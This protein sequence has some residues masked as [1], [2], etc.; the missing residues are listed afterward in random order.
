MSLIPVNVEIRIWMCC[1][2][3]DVWLCVVNDLIDA[4]DISIV[5]HIDIICVAQS[6]WFSGNHWFGVHQPGTVMMY[7]NI[8]TH[9]RW[10][11]TWAR[12]TWHCRWKMF[13]GIEFRTRRRVICV[14][15]LFAMPGRAFG[16]W[17]WCMRFRT[18]SWRWSMLAKTMW[19]RRH[20]R[21][22]SLEHTQ[23]EWKFHF[24][25]ASNRI[26]KFWTDLRHLNYEAHAQSKLNGLLSRR[27]ELVSINLFLFIFRGSYSAQNLASLSHA[28]FT[29]QLW[30][31]T[32]FA[33]VWHKSKI[34][35]IQLSKLAKCTSTFLFFSSFVF[36]L[37]SVFNPRHNF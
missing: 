31:M 17:R 1:G 12:L 8:L 15:V 20:R 21:R 5:E 37:L 18:T 32:S 13:N 10:L 4:I 9:C 7:D 16:A 34:Q 23:T 36:L 29:F 25:F 28:N 6:M 11:D 22:R 14:A 2:H 27:F 35:T 30:F 3:T 19:Q 26:R 33:F 24:G